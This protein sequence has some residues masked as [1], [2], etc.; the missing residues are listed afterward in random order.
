MTSKRQ[1]LVFYLPKIICDIGCV[2]SFII[3]MVALNYVIIHSVLNHLYLVN[4]LLSIGTL[5]R[6]RD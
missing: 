2:A 6:V 5:G 3:T 4:T 1:A